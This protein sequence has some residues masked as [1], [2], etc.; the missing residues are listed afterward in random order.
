VPTA[1]QRNAI[2]A[3]AGIRRDLFPDAAAYAP[4]PVLEKEIE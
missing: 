1:A 2:A 4:S 3:L